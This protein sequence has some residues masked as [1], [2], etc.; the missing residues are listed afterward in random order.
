MYKMERVK[1]MIVG[2]GFLGLALCVKS[3][4]SGK[5]AILLGF[6]LASAIVVGPTILSRKW[7]LH[8]PKEAKI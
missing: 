6:I 8:K 3:A 1:G 4:Y 2:F 5:H 7:K